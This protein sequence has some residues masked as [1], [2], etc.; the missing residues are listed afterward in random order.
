MQ[1]AALAA[2]LRGHCP[3]RGNQWLRFVSI[4][5]FCALLAA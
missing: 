3:F 4:L 2:T 1:L 5:V